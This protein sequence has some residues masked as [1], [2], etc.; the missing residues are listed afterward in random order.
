MKALSQDAEDADRAKIIIGVL[1]FPIG[2]SY[3]IQRHN[4]YR[5]GE[6]MYILSTGSWS[7][8]HKRFGREVRKSPILRD[9]INVLTIRE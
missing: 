9:V 5:V 8:G 3:R 6:K 2:I 1:A 7:Q 4:R